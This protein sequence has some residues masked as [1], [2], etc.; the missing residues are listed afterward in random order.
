M[1]R[2]SGK[3]WKDEAT[4]WV[5]K[6][7]DAT[8]T[9]PPTSTPAPDPVQPAQS[10][11]KFEDEIV[12]WLASH[13]A[14]TNELYVRGNDAY[15]IDVEESSLGSNADQWPSYV[16]IHRYDA[17]NDMWRTVKA[18]EILEPGQQY[19]IKVTKSDLDK[20]KKATQGKK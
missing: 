15:Y 14:L 10:A 19:R 4:G 9:L 7:E 5:D 8:K 20:A 2:A 17:K 18:G 16:D 13:Y 1:D 11:G 6:P 3:V 12:A